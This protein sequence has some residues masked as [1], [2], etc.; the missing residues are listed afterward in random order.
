M[1]DK[2]TVKYGKVTESPGRDIQ[3]PL[4]T[5]TGSKFLAH[6]HLSYAFRKRKCVCVCVC[7]CVCARVCEK[8]KHKHWR[9]Q[10]CTLLTFGSFCS[11]YQNLQE[12]QLSC[13]YF[14]PIKLWK[15]LSCKIH[16][17]SLLFLVVTLLMKAS[18][19]TALENAM[20]FNFLDSMLMHY[21]FLSLKKTFPNKDLMFSA[22]FFIRGT[23][24]W[25]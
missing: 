19:K 23:L 14:P 5:I 12:Y 24:P 3:G 11:S 16:L 6:S 17:F 18:L 10:E 25:Q 2:E 9:F 15:Y 4:P 1:N 13:G 20:H 7:V 21:A 8:E 22:F